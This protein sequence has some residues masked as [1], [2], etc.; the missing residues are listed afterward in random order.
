M[1]T[2]HQFRDLME[3]LSGI[4][5]KCERLSKEIFNVD[6]GTV[7]VDQQNVQQELMSDITLNLIPGETR[8]AP[9]IGKFSNRIIEA[10]D[11]V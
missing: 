3:L 8:L 4:V 1:V 10:A 11:I 6:A 5:K 9:Q 7:V 2:K